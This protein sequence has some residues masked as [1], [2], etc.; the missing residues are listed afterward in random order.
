MSNME[1]TIALVLFA[2]VFIGF[3]ILIAIITVNIEHKIKSEY[4]DKL[5]NRCIKAKGVD[6][7]KD[8]LEISKNSFMNRKETIKL[9]E[10]TCNISHEPTIPENF[11]N[12]CISMFNSI[13]IRNQ[14]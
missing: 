6:F 2:P 8:V 14:I 5:L 9:L 10:R 7:V 13:S 1:F 4:M 12:K 3:A 11:R